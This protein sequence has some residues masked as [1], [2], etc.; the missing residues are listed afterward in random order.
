MSE[1]FTSVNNALNL[2]Q[3]KYQLPDHSYFN[4]ERY[5]WSIGFLDSPEMY[6]ARM[7]EYP[8]A[9]LSADPHRGAR[10]ADIGCGMT[11]FTIYLKEALDCDVVGVDPE[12]FSK[13]IRNTG[14]GVSRE[15][16]NKT[17]LNIIHCGMEIIALPS[18]SF[19]FVFCLSVIE[20][21]PHWIAHLGIQEMARIL[22]PGGKLIITV[23]VDIN[24]EIGV[25][26]GLIS[27]PLLFHAG[28]ISLRWPLHRFGMHP[29]SRK[30]LDVYGISLVKSDRPVD[31]EYL[32]ES[33]PVDSATHRSNI[34]KLIFNKE[35]IVFTIQ[36]GKELVSHLIG[37]VADWA[38]WTVRLHR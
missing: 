33:V 13:G 30:P 10:C 5:P 28:E 26:L 25:P 12:F 8:F 22:K 4:K 16:I 1:Q 38:R 32:G 15:F 9:V 29:N 36:S 11:A 20:H 21:V 23:D 27:D 17:G 6:A 2:I 7:W 31:R 3:S 35:A 24:S 19:D 14:H 34:V 18:D 37:D